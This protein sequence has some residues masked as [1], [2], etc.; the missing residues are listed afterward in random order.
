M[1]GNWQGVVFAYVV[2]YS[3]CVSVVIYAPCV[4]TRLR[5][6]AAADFCRLPISAAHMSTAG[7]AAETA[8][9]ADY[10]VHIHDCVSLA[11]ECVGSVMD[12]VEY[13]AKQKRGGGHNSKRK[14]ARNRPSVFKIS[15][16]RQ[17]SDDPEDKKWEE[18]VTMSRYAALS[19]TAVLAPCFMLL[20]LHRLF[21]PPWQDR[22]TVGPTLGRGGRRRARRKVWSTRVSMT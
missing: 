10:N 20:I 5:S 7:G 3:E 21:A 18:M 22:R 19:H 6:S 1:L 4:A 17:T 2:Q 14:R 12:G 9:Y 8:P 15:A 13:R 11:S 16:L